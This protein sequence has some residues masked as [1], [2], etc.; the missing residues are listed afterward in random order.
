MQQMK[1]NKKYISIKQTYK[2]KTANYKLV[3]KFPRSTL[4]F[5]KNQLTM[6]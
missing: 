2:K 6:N 5:I 4:K 3:S 1:L